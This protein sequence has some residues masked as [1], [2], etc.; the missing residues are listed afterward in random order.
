VFCC[1]HP[2]Y[3]SIFFSKKKG[4]TEKILKIAAQKSH[5]KTRPRTMDLFK[6]M[7]AFR[8]NLPLC[9]DFSR[10]LPFFREIKHIFRILFRPIPHGKKS[11]IV[12]KAEKCRFSK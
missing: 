6:K 3:Y 1:H 11:K 8:V 10:F 7:H 4:R 9:V 5:D 2:P 12:G